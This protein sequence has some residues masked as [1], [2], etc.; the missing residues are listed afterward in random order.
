MRCPPEAAAPRPA[1][2]ALTV[3]VEDWYQSYVDNDAPLSSRVVDNTEVV[4]EF[5]D[6]SGVKAT[7]FVLGE[8]ARRFPSLVARIHAA[9]HEVQCHGE[10]HV[11]IASFRHRQLV[12]SLLRARHAIEDA[13]GARVR[14]FRAPYFSVGAGRIADVFDALAEAEFDVDSSIFPV[15]MRRYGVGDWPLSPTYVP[16]KRGG[17]LLEAP[18]AAFTWLGRRVPVAGGGYL[19]AMPFRIARYAIER[20]GRQGRPAILYMH[21]YEFDAR[22]VN[23][24]RDA[25][26]WCGRMHQGIGRAAL[27][28]RMRALLRCCA[29]DRLDRALSASGTP[30]PSSAMTT[31]KTP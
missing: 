2:S 8:V 3:D 7:F 20:I 16:M 10:R 26:G 29:F 19:R 18:V 6:V 1:L 25:V 31:R 5:L 14:A 28:R 24:Y 22:E 21:P 27:V 13:C 9:G 17:C 23:A 15:Q 12:D 30:Y 4:L 11:S